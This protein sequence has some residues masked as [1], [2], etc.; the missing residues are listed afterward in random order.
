MTTVQLAITDAEYLRTLRALL[1][2]DGDHDVVAVDYPSP[3]GKGLVV[4]DSDLLGDL[5]AIADPQR[6]IVIVPRKAYFRTSQLWQAG[7]RN[8]VFQGDPPSTAHLAVLSLEFRRRAGDRI[9]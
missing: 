3:H 7:F 8:V 2:Q 4:A 1:T 5:S 6:F 9:R